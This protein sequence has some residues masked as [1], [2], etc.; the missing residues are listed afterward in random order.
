MR[1]VPFL[2]VLTALFVTAA[3]TAD[4]LWNSGNFITSGSAPSVGWNQTY[5]TPFRFAVLDD[6]ELTAPAD[7]TRLTFYCYSS[8]NNAGESRV[9]A[10]YV[11]ILTNADNFPGQVIFGGWVEPLPFETE[12]TGLNNSGSA[13]SPIYRVTVFLPSVRLCP[14]RYWI[15]FNVDHNDVRATTGNHDAQMFAKIVKPAPADANGKQLDVL[16]G[17]YYTLNDITAPFAP[18]APVFVIEGTPYVSCPTGGGDQDGDGVCTAADV[19]LFVTRLLSGTF[20]GCADA[21]GDCVADGRDV[22]AFVNCV[23]S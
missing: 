6:F 12:Y 17:Q 19:P 3:A 21:N 23:G 11:R 7:L 22:Q 15:E 20:H 8:G 4:V 10:A 14:G 13:T 9:L 2:S 16:T 18:N 5:T 1:R